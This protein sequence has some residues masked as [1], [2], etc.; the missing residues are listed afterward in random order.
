[1]FY[2]WVIVGA[3]ASIV[4]LAYVVW[5]S[6]A[7]FLVALVAE[8][9]WG[10]AETGGAFSLFVLIHSGASPLVGRLV[11]RIGFRPMV[12]GGALL[13]GVALL[14]CSQIT[15]LWQFYLCF[16]VLAAIGVTTMGW[17]P[18]ST[19]LG[20]WFSRRLGLAVGIGGAGIGLGTFFAA[21][22]VQ[23]TIDAY[24]WRAAY[25]VLAVVLALGPQ[26]LALLLRARPEAL[27][28][29][30]DGVPLP[31][32]G[33][34]ATAAAD[35]PTGA[36]R[37]PGWD[38]RVVDAAWMG[39]EWTVGRALR[40]RR[41]YLLFGTFMLV[42]FAIQQTYAHQA[43]YLVGSGYAP[44]FVATVLGFIGIASVL[45]K[46]VVGTLSDALGREVMV[47]VG[48]G[49]GIAALGVLL[50]L[51]DG[52]RPAALLYAYAALFAVGYS[53][54]APMMPAICADL[55]YGR[56]YGT[57]YGLVNVS[58]GVGGAIGGWLA[59]YIYDQTGAYQGAWV[60]G[61]A[62]LGLAILLVWLVAPRRVLRTPGQARRA[63]RTAAR[64]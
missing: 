28:V 52:D 59:G 43:A 54:A 61:M 49:G 33:G 35:S 36:G 7:L 15:A 25:V 27:G 39:Q 29:G 19:L 47:T 58:G 18:G 38:P 3:V 23:F 22:P 8:F 14:G 64:A 37:G 17:I 46:V 9:G 12:H 30:R 41:F 5:Y 34:E 2:G 11:D 13:V 20:R 26:P 57:I 53:V 16:G 60:L 21:P 56:R 10:R 62:A 4:A 63:A 42:S 55:F 40:T 32:E 6:F 50:S 45:G 24:G 44:L 48:L 51:A 31:K 1:M